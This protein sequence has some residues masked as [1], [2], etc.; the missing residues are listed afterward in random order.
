MNGHLCEVFDGVRLAGARGSNEGATREG[1]EGDGEGEERP[2]CEGC[3]HEARVR[4]EVLHVVGEGR[5][6]L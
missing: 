1:L 5:P 4:S 6:H 2:L 3:E